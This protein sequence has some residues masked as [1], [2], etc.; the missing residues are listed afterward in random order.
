[1]TSR[2]V[3]TFFS[4]SSTST[5]PRPGRFPFPGRP[6][7]GYSQ[8]ASA[9][10]NALGLAV[11]TSSYAS[12]YPA[13]VNGMDSNVSP[14]EYFPYRREEATTTDAMME[15]IAR[16]QN[17]HSAVDSVPYGPQDVVIPTISDDAQWPQNTYMHHPETYELQY[18]SDYACGD[19]IHNPQRGHATQYYNTGGIGFLPSGTP[20]TGNNLPPSYSPT[21]QYLD[22]HAPDSQY[23]SPDTDA[24]S[25]SHHE[26]SPYRRR[27]SPYRRQPTSYTGSSVHYPEVYHSSWPQWHNPSIGNPQL[28]G[29]SF[30]EQLGP[31]MAPSPSAATFSQ[32]YMGRGDDLSNPPYP[33]PHI[34]PNQNLLRPN[35]YSRQS[36]R[37]R[38][39]SHTHE[40]YHS[41][42]TTF[43]CGWLIGDHKTCGY[44]GPLNAFK[45]HFRSSHLSGAQNAPNECRWQGCTYRKRN[46][47]TVHAMRRDSAWRHVWETH[48]GMKR[49]I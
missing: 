34:Q 24:S 20:V 14:N 33:P 26:S 12:T 36:S 39:G 29:S 41:P 35:S 18:N 46:D 13:Y 42:S 9:A 25:S 11:D 10:A 27:P 40:T 43:S 47:A 45:T 38:H 3:R 2:P 48:L 16:S 44:Q 6:R 37:R 31:S 28:A 4:D 32:P 23:T 19:P 49:I 8:N 17:Y 30:P 21:V 5:N 22:G 15:N 7:T 1:M